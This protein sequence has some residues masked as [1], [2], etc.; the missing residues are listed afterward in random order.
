MLARQSVFPTYLKVRV[1]QNLVT[2]M[3]RGD[4]AALEG[5]IYLRSEAHEGS[6]G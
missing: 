4:L 1:F 2:N 3:A 6:P 5:L